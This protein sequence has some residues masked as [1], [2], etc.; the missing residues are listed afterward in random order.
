MFSSSHNFL[1]FR[2]VTQGKK[3]CKI[4]KIG[5]GGFWPWMKNIAYHVSLSVNLF[6]KSETKLV[7]SFFPQFEKYQLSHFQAGHFLKIFS[8]FWTFWAPFSH[9]SFSYIKKTCS[10]EKNEMGIIFNYSHQNKAQ[11]CTFFFISN[12]GVWS[13]LELLIFS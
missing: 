7:W 9:K 6:G 1:H 4:C 13:V 11:P 8:A 2:A 12:L 3:V 10:G 5:G